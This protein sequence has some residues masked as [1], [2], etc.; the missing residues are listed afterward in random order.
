MGEDAE[1][2]HLRVCAAIKTGAP[3]LFTATELW[4]TRVYVADDVRTNETLPWS[5]LLFC[6]SA[7]TQTGS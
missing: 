7:I 3:E 5:A 1:K 6:P 4:K 2:V